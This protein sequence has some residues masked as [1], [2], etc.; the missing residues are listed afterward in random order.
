ML[1]V[2]AITTDILFSQTL[3]NNIIGVFKYLAYIFLIQ[4]F[5]I[6]INISLTIQKLMILV[7]SK[8]KPNLFTKNS[9]FS[10]ILKLRK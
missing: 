5:S 2:P 1:D 4:Y 9:K 8:I 3:I 6:T 7:Q 10:D